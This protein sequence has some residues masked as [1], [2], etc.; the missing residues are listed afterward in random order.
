MTLRVAKNLRKFAVLMA[1]G[2]LAGCASEQVM[3][4]LDSAVAQALPSSQPLATVKLIDTRRPGVATSKRETL[5]MPMGTIVF[6]PPEASI[7][8]RRLEFDLTQLLRQRG[9]TTPQSY[10]CEVRELGVNTNSTPLYWDL[11]G[12]AHI[13]LR[14]NGRVH[15][16]TGTGSERTFVWPGEAVIRDAFYGSLNDLSAKLRLVA[17]EL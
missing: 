5:G 16:L 4:R 8:K 1:A 2:V 9:D 3:V 14:S 12:V 17:A 10:E 6:E 15:E 7:L 11:I 13:V